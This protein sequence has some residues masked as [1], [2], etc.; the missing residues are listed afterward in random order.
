M[1]GTV[2][3]VQLD[4]TRIVMTGSDTDRFRISIIDRTVGEFLCP[5]YDFYRARIILIRLPPLLEP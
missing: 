1:I 4:R 2:E 3:F 5:G